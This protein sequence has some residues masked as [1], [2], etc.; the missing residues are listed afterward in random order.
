MQKKKTPLTRRVV[1]YLPENLAEAIEGK[2][3]ALE[4]DAS[5]FYRMLIKK[6][7]EAEQLCNA[8]DA[9]GIP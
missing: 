1:T 7:W 8:G 9:Q 2:A 3:I 4:R 5:V 6:G